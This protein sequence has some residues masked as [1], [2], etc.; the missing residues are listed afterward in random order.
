MLISLYRKH[1]TVRKPPK[2]GGKIL[3]HYRENLQ[4]LLI[5]KVWTL[6]WLHKKHD[7]LGRLRPGCEIYTMV[8]TGAR[9][10]HETVRWVIYIPVWAE[11]ICR[12]LWKLPL[13]IS[14]LANHVGIA[15]SSAG[16]SAVEETNAMS[17]TKSQAI[18]KVEL[19]K[20]LFLWDQ[21]SELW[22]FVPDVK[23]VLLFP[24]KSIQSWKQHTETWRKSFESKETTSLNRH[25]NINITSLKWRQPMKWRSSN[26]K[27]KSLG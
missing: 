6:I 9:G 2:S 23:F 19:M 15:C 12:V 14:T 4:G 7:T 10:I 1:E 18:W 21:Q 20:N 25:W 11:I 8:C 13:L 3:W 26:L 16:E 24:R 27:K 17:H 5:L 22:V